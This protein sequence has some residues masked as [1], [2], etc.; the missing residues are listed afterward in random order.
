MKTIYIPGTIWGSHSRGYED[1]S[2]PVCYV[3]LAGLLLGLFLDPE[4]W[5]DMSLW[6]ASW[7]STDYTALYLFN[8]HIV[9]CGS[10]Y[11]RG[12]GLAHRFIGYSQVV[13]TDSS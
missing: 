13:T 8:F 7:L 4:D 11:W 6:N 1:F 3:L 9:T 12:S 2:G 10:D 5:S